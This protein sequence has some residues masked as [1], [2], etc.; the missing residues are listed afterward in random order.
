MS[1]PFEPPAAEDDPVRRAQVLA[2]PTLPKRFYA[3]VAVGEAE[4]GWVVL[5]DGRPARTPAK[6]IAVVPDR[7][8]AEALASEWGAQAEEIDPRRMPLLRLVNSALDGVVHAMAEVREGIAGVGA[9]DLLFYRPEGPERLVER[10]AAAW[11]PIVAWA[12]RRLGVRFVLAEGLM[13]V[14]QDP[15][16]L[17]ALRAAVPEGPPLL[18]AALHQLATLTGSALIALAIAEG[19]LTLAEGWV[20]AHIDEDWTSE[21]WGVDAEAAARRAG[22]EAEA[23]AA[24][25]VVTCLAHG[26]DRG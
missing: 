22:Y 26:P 5:L 25:L 19:R 10:A 21:L 12:E 7:R 15:A 23:R 24:A 20:A 14:S 11:D 17:A 16:A 9:T 4:G 8:I 13:P 2:R 18:V 1:T 3:A 6:A